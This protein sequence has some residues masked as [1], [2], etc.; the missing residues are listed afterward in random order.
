VVKGYE[1]ET[2]QYVLIEDQELKKLA[3]ESG[4][5]MEITEFVELAE[6][7]PLYFETSYLAT[8]EK[9]G[10]KA[11]GLLVKALEKTGKAGLAKVVMHRREYLVAIRSREQGLTLHTMYFNNEIREVADYGH[12]HVD[13]KPQEVKLA[14]ELIG[15]LSKQFRPEKYRNEYQAKLREFVES[16]V[17][18]RK[19]PLAAARKPAPVIDMMEALKRSLA[20]REEAKRE[21]AAGHI[22]HHRAAPRNARSRRKAS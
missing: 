6:I 17:K 15:N 8:P 5:A 9:S 12:Q 14:T 16:K 13:L 2:G 7:D 22:S 1:Y 3:P 11:Y 20:K 21:E 4:G 19:P 10:A 18:G